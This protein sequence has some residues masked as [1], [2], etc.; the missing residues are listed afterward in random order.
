MLLN[1]DIDL[2]QAVSQW[3]AKIIFWNLIEALQ[4]QITVRAGEK[5][6]RRKNLSSSHFSLQRSHEF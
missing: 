1:E 2:S 5:G 3:T 4:S 6:V